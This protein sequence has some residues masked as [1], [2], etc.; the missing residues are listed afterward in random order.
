MYSFSAFR[1]PSHLGASWGL[2]YLF[3]FGKI[4]NNFQTGTFWLFFFLENT[5]QISHWRLCV[6]DPQ[7]RCD[8]S[9]LNLGTVAKDIWLQLHI[10]LREINTGD[11][12]PYTWTCWPPPA[13]CR[14]A[15]SPPEG[16]CCGRRWRHGGGRPKTLR[17]ALEASFFFFEFAK[18]KL[19]ALS[20]TVPPYQWSCL[21]RSCFMNCL[22]PRLLLRSIAHAQGIQTKKSRQWGRG[23]IF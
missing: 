17:S 5:P 16:S 6:W 18:V 21:L 1:T 23:K 10:V 14:L 19:S 2:A 4:I 7:E 20:R 12:F 22:D 11:S 8:G 15:E 9:I 13:C 3:F